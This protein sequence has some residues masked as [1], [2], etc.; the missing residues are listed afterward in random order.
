MAVDAKEIE[1]L[2]EKLQKIGRRIDAVAHRNADPEVKWLVQ[3]TLRLLQA[4]IELFSHLQRLSDTGFVPRV[5]LEV[6]MKDEV[7]K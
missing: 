3:Y 5:K 1:Q 7:V 2:Y 4:D 6:A